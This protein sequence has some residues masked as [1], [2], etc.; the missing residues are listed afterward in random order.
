MSYHDS[1]EGN[2]DL[3]TGKISQGRDIERIDENAVHPR[4]CENEEQNE[5]AMEKS[6]LNGSE[7]PLRWQGHRASKWII[8][9]EARMPSGGRS[10]RKGKFS[11]DNEDDESDSAK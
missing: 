11:E 6:L 5:E 10:A 1:D 9:H 7:V 2:A 4:H 3:R 8:H